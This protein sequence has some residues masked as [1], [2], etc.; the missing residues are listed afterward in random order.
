[1]IWPAEVV[2]QTIELSSDD[3]VMD[4]HKNLDIVDILELAYEQA[5]EAKVNRLIE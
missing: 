4:P 3:E 5:M 1:M 2:P